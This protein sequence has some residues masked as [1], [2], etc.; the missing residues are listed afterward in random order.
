MKR[1][2][3]SDFQDPNVIFQ[4]VKDVV[5]KNKASDLFHKAFLRPQ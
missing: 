2:I 4:R 3:S 1:Q 5:D